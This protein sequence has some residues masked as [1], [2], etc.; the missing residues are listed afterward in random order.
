MRCVAAYG[1]LLDIS[2]HSSPKGASW[3]AP[4]QHLGD[5]VEI[6]CIN[7]GF[8]LDSR[9]PSSQVSASDWAPGAWQPR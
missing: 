6:C 1:K 2:S 4:V 3:V 5:G 8:I 9:L 7:A